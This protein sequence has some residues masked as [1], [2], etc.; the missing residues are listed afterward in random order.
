MGL[1]VTWALIVLKWRRSLLREF[2]CE[3][4]REWPRRWSSLPTSHAF[5]TRL[6]NLDLT[7]AA[8]SLPLAVARFWQAEW[9]D[10][11][12]TNPWT[13]AWAATRSRVR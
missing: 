4:G 1:C 7:A 8:L 10:L 3:F 2:L 12:R 5:A 13:P 9:L 6:S 11:L